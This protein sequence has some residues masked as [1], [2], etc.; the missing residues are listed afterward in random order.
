MVIIWPWAE[1][2]LEAA[3]WSTFKFYMGMD[4]EFLVAIILHVVI[5]EN[6]CFGPCPA[7]FHII[8]ASRRCLLI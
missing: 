5:T 4:D 7:G 1:F 6:D 2:Y 8:E 3:G